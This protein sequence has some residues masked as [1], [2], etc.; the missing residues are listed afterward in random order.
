MKK[1]RW[2]YATVFKMLVN[3]LNKFFLYEMCTNKRKHSGSK[4]RARRWHGEVEKAQK[5]VFLSSGN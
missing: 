1:E 4:L 5:G 2:V 3:I